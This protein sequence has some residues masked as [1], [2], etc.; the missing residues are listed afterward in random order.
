MMMHHAAATLR[1]G[2]TRLVLL[3]LVAFGLLAMLYA[4]YIVP[5]WNYARFELEPNGFKLAAALCAIS[6]FSL[7]TPTESGAR[8][9][10]L[11][12]FLTIYLLPSMVLYAYGGHATAAAVIIWT[13]LAIVYAV[14]AIRLP[15][16]TTFRIGTRSTMWILALAAVGLISAFHVLGGFRNF[17]LNLAEIYDFRREAA[18]DLPGIFGYIRPAFANVVIPFGI[19][20][21]LVHRNHAMVAFFLVISVLLFGLSGHKGILFSPIFAAGAYF[22]LS[23]YGRYSAVLAVFI[24][25]LLLG[26]VDA[27]MLFATGD[28]SVYG[29]YDSLLVRRALMVPAILDY[30]YIEFFSQNQKYYWASSRITFDLVPN[31]YGV[32]APRMIGEVYYGSQEAN[33]NTG[34]IGSGYAQAGLAGVVVYSVGVGLVLSVFQ[35]YARYMGLP[36][37]VAATS[38]LATVITSVDFLTLFLTQGLL[39]LLLLLTIVRSPLEEATARRWRPSPAAS[40]LQIG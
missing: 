23:R 38:G 2:K 6:M 20:L 9:F 27:A 14:S 11:N 36:F 18:E 25:A 13:A 17:N 8:S 40:A 30:Q 4:Y 22:F 10:F 39:F 34:F 37:I 31:P 7:A 3:Y 33:S 5:V 15:R 29:W 16:L 1:D 24:A 21:A 26:F 28:D 19:A 32:V 12:L 35:S